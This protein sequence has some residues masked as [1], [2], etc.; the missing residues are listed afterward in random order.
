MKDVLN[1]NK[2]VR[3]EIGIADEK[4]EEVLLSSATELEFWVKTPEE[5]RDIEELSTSQ[6]LKEQ[7]WKRTEG[8]VRTAMEYCLLEIGRA[9]V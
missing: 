7:Y 4:V 8:N 1:N 9:H 6:V 2:S 5:I 3:E